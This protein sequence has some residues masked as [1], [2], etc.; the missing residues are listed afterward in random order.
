M[1][2]ER[3]VVLGYSSMSNISFRGRYDTGILVEEWEEMSEADQ[4]EVFNE[5]LNDL[6]DI[7]VIHEEN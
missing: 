4:A 7:F 3:T 2:E 5:V 6:V 1:E